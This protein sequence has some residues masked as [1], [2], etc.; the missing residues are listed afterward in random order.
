VG[1][2]VGPGPDQ[3]A[4]PGSGPSALRMSNVRRA[5][6]ADRKQRGG[7][8]RWVASQCRAAVPL[9]G[10]FGLSAGAGQRAGRSARGSA[11]EGTEVGRLE[12]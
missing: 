10:G 7:T 8:D 4:A 9:T 2:V 1:G 11:R 3:R 5:C 6:V 12:E